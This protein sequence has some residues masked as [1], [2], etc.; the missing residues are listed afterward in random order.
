MTKYLNNN[1]YANA[2]VNISYKA[3]VTSTT[4]NNSIIPNDGENTFA[5]A[6]DTLYTGTVTLTKT[7]RKR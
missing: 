3:E 6:T 4:V 7:G 5:P 2:T 1:A